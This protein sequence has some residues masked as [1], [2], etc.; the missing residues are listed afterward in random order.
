MMDKIDIE[1]LI[2]LG[3]WTICGPIE[4]GD[5]HLGVGIN[6]KVLMG[7]SIYRSQLLD[8]FVC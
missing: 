8:V 5:P 6:E 7:T 3:A 2:G 1:N 4:L